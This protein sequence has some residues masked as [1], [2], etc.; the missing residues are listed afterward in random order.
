MG[1]RLITL[2][3]ASNLI[4]NEI[5][6]IIEKSSVYES[7]PWGFIHPNKFLN[8]VLKVKTEMD[9]EALLILLQKIEKV[10]GRQKS[11][12]RYNART[13]DID[14][15][16]YEDLVINSETL[17]VPHPRMADRRFVLVP[18]CELIP[19]FQHPVFKVPVHELLDLC[20]DKAEVNVFDTP[21]SI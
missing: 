12:K 17:V 18:L 19:A 1:D 10:L 3:K 11:N 4:E 15:L 2:E 9:P 13:I 21:E 7:D 8:Q 16:F 5:G 6:S 20:K 14:I